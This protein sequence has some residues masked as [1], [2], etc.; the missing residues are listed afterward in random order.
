MSLLPP[1]A[2]LPVIETACFSTFTACDRALDTESPTSIAKLQDDKAPSSKPSSDLA[3]AH[4]ALAA[5]RYMLHRELSCKRTV[6]PAYGEREAYTSFRPEWRQI[7][8]QFLHAIASSL[9]MS[10]GTVGLAMVFLD[11]TLSV[12]AI[13]SEHVQRYAVVSLLVAAK[14]RETRYTFAEDGTP[15]PKLS[16]VRFVHF[17]MNGDCYHAIVAPK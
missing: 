7:L 4:D 11:S 15:L 13:E 17:C 9:S 1:A 12:T 6:D 10:P 8:V 14:L 16:L 3:V 2:S 5:L